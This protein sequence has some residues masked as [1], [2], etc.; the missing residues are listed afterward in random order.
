MNNLD[1]CDVFDDDEFDVDGTLMMDQEQQQQF[2]VLI[3]NYERSCMLYNLTFTNGW[4]IAM[5]CYPGW[6]SA[7]P[8]PRV[9]NNN[10]YWDVTHAEL[11]DDD[12]SPRSYKANYRVN[13]DTFNWLVNTLS[14][15]PAYNTNGS[16]HPVYIQVACVLWRFANAHF[17]YRMASIQM[18]ISQGSYHKFTVRFLEA[19]I[20]IH[21][22]VISWPVGEELDRVEEG[23]RGVDKLPGGVVGA[24]DGKLVVIHKPH[25]VN[26]E[27]YRDRKGHLSINLLAVC[28]SNR[29]FTFVDIGN[30]GRTHDARAFNNS[31][32]ARKLMDNS[33]QY[34]PNDT[35]IVGDSAYPLK[36]NLITPYS[37]NL[38]E[39]S[40][41]IRRFNFVH[42]STRIVIERT[43]GLLVQ[44]WRFLKQY[45]FLTTEER[46]VRVIHVSC[47]LHNICL[48]RG[49]DFVDESTTE[50][51]EL[52]TIAENDNA[53]GSLEVVNDVDNAPQLTS[54]RERGRLAA[55][56]R[57]DIRA[58]LDAQQ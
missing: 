43:F 13:R 24:I 45:L 7:P 58:L 5:S 29:R 18:S 36:H 1:L 15:H 12:E 41:S 49:D 56:R 54:E 6:F 21:G 8:S 48:G 46:L 23:F 16:Q 57:N 55:T 32:L 2:L 3:I 44:R 4:N 30:P 52:E 22:G 47:I 37:R 26:A 50:H 31:R 11:N 20:D 14:V 51:A 33:Q 38:E 25:G 19:M 35:Y 42:S 34:T 10:H 28:D 27:F 40:P 9:I 17:G 39:S 53:D